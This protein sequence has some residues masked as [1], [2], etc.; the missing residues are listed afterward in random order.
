MAPVRFVVHACA[1]PQSLAR[2]ISHFAQLGLIP[3]RVRAD[4]A[5]GQILVRI[6]Q[7]DMGEHQAR[8]IAEKMR[9][10]VLVNR[11]DLYRGRRRIPPVGE[12][13]DL[14]MRRRPSP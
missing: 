1:D 10:A 14:E 12:C 5:E 9:S 7:Q 2:I 3:K 6:E 11:V 13:I 8:I 4:E